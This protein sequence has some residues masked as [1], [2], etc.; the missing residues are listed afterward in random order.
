V[1]AEVIASFEARISMRRMGRPEEVAR[2]VA[3][4]AADASAYVTGQVWGVNGGLD[5]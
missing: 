5:M 3:F 2:V 4:P 1:P